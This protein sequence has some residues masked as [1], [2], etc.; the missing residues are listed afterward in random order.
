MRDTRLIDRIG[1]I[2]GTYLVRLS[3]IPLVRTIAD[4]YWCSVAALVLFVVFWSFPSYDVALVLHEVDANWDALFLQAAE[5]FTDH[6]Q[7]HDARSHG[8]KLGFRMVP[9]LL[10]RLL[11][12]DTVPGALVLQFVLLVLF[13]ALLLLVLRD[14]LGNKRW[15]FA[16]AFAFSLILCGHVYTVDYGGLFDTLAFDLLLVAILLRRRAWMVIPLLLAYFTD[17]RA[18]IASPAVVLLGLYERDEHASIRTMLRG[19]RSG[20]A[21]WTLISWGC[22]FLVRSCL[23]HF[24]GLVTVPVDVLHFMRQNLVRWPYALYI[25]IEGFVVPFVIIVLHFL[26]KEW[27]AFALAM[28][29]VFF[30]LNIVAMSV[31]DINRSMAYVLPLL[32]L[33]VRIA[34]PRFDRTRAVHVLGWVILINLLYDDAWPLPAQ[35][36]RMIHLTGTL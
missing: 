34:H 18:L 28:V 5:P 3:L 20:V 16:W 31:H 33:I 29:L 4:R 14:V 15:A 10:L 26:R 11:S 27:R 21:R 35:L 12:I 30:I 1:T 8:A 19:C 25:G 13:Q 36:Y 7:V 23:A 17:E 32:L 24:A 2:P 9:A 22:Y 6:T